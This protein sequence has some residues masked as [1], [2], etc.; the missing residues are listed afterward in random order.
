MARRWVKSI[1]YSLVVAAGV[2]LLW[3]Q[4][5]SVQSMIRLNGV[6]YHVS[7]MRTDLE[8]EKGLSGTEKLPEGNAMLFVFPQSDTWRMWM[9]DMNYP[10][11]IVWVND[12]GQVVH[13]VSDAQPSSY[14]KTMFQPDTPARYIIEFPAGTVE[15]TRIQNGNPVGLPSGV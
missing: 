13:T 5:A 12:A 2:A 1:V 11:D 3:W 6:R 14:P 10:V 7:I 15:K 4:M 8:R 9:K